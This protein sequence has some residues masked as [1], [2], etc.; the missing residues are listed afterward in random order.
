MLLQEKVLKMSMSD[1]STKIIKQEQ[2][3]EETWEKLDINQFETINLSEKKPEYDF[4][5]LKPPNTDE[6]GFSPFNKGTEDSEKIMNREKNVPQ[7]DQKN[8]VSEQ[9]AYEKGFSQGE[10]DGF[11]SGEKKALKKAEV[12]NKILSEMENFHKQIQ[13]QCERQVLDLIVGVAEKVIQR[14]IDLDKTIIGKTILNALQF[15]SE[16]NRVTIRINPDD[17]DYINKFK[18]QFFLEHRD[19]KSVSITPDISVTKGGCLL[20]TSYGDIDATLETQL[21][22]IGKSLT[23]AFDQNGS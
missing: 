7:T 11:K 1:G 4:I 12:I 20:E 22:K 3:K 18:T 19:L 17:V 10:K 13:T 16:K 23:T 6:T 2:L 8:D 15:I 9:K 14:E 5:S 21:E